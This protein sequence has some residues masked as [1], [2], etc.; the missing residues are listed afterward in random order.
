MAQLAERLGFDLTDPLAGYVKLFADFFQ[1]VVGVHIDTKTHAQH[2]GFAGGQATEYFTGCFRQTLFGR[3]LNRRRNSEVL[4]EVTQMRIFII[5]DGRFHRDRFLGDLEDLAHLV[6]WHVH[7]LTKLF[8][9]RLAAHLLQHLTRDTV[10]LVDRFDHM[11][12][13]TNG[14]GLIGN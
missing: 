5:A 2:L 9:G 11:N 10:Q 1:R 6:L 14:A 4:D 8:G 13:N 7:A 3:R 12:R